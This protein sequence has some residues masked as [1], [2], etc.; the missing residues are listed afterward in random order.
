MKILWIIF[1]IVFISGCEETSVKKI[2]DS[3]FISSN[4]SSATESDSLTTDSDSDSAVEADPCAENNGGCG[5]VSYAVCEKKTGGFACLCSGSYIPTKDDK[6]CVP[7]YDFKGPVYH[8]DALLV[9]NK[10]PDGESAA[11]AGTLPKSA[12]PAGFKSL[13]T[14]ISSFTAFSRVIPLPEHADRS[15]L[16]QKMMAPAP[17]PTIGDEKKF[18]AVDFATMKNYQLDAKAI[19]VGKYCIMWAEKP[20]VISTESAKAMADEFDSKIYQSDTENFY[21]MS[22]VDGNGKV[23]MLFLDSH[24]QVGGYFNPY[25]L[26]D[27]EDSNKTD[28]INIDQEVANFGKD[29]AAMVLV[30]EFQHLCHNN[31]D[32]LIEKNQTYFPWIGEG[33][34]TSSEHV[35]LG[36]REDWLDAYNTSETISAG[37]PVTYFEWTTTYDVSNYGLTYLFH[38]YLRIHAKHGN[39]IYREIIMDENNDYQAYDN[40]IKKYIDPNLTFGD[41][42]VN[43]RIALIMNEPVGLYGFGGEKGFTGFTRHYSTV[44][45]EEIYLRGSGALLFQIKVPFKEKGD[46]ESDISM[47]GIHLGKKTNDNASEYTD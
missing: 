35:Y 47:I 31:R 6:K 20:V 27:Y 39:A 26:Y 12:M 13:T 45:T 23:T 19:Y 36:F 25:D 4:D 2:T 9:I 34:S 40:I 7:R 3:D 11:F 14:N 46:K 38:Q 33:L 16:M 10:S 28:M 44:D 15:R 43:F 8:G 30:H 18:W 22:D 32:V 42:L 29:Y 24:G 1:V 17:D 21:E 5:D 41:M 37:L